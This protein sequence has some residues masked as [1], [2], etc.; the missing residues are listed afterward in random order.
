[1]LVIC[2]LWGRRWLL[3]LAMV[4]VGSGS[5]GRRIPLPESPRLGPPHD[6]MRLVS[7]KLWT[8]GML[9]AGVARKS[10]GLCLVL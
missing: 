10:T 5:L 4:V 8:Q 6:A 3:R 7:W 9:T 2:R 1:M